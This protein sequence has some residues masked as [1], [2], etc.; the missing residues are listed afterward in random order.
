MLSQ[1][2]GSIYKRNVLGL[3]AG[4][5][6][7]VCDN[8]EQILSTSP[9][10]S[11]R[12]Y[13]KASQQYCVSVYRPQQAYTLQQH[14]SYRAL[15][16]HGLA[17][18][19]LQPNI[20]SEAHEFSRASACSWCWVPVPVPSKTMHFIYNCTVYVVSKKATIISVLHVWLP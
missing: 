11:A 9:W 2:R 5:P 10:L 15:S 16:Q 17:R 8:A 1:E 4:K 20:G 12:G 6:A 18:L 14:A 13:G 3:Q 19:V 7:P